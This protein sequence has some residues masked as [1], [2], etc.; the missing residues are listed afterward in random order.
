MRDAL[1][2]GGGE[3][4]YFSPIFPLLLLKHEQTNKERERETERERGRYE[5]ERVA[6]FSKLGRRCNPPHPH[7]ALPTNTSVNC[8]C[9]A[10][11]RATGSQF[12]AAAAAAAGAAGGG[13]GGSFTRRNDAG[14]A[15][16]TDDLRRAAQEVATTALVP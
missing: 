8:P 3:G 15:A 11:P 7:S 13:G 14:S 16:C 10:R 6:F 4:H 2:E 12:R 9:A 5:L 1:E